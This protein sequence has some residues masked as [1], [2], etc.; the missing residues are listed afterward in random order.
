MSG[1]EIK[2]GGIGLVRGELTDGS[3]DGQVKGSCIKE[4]GSN[5]PPRWIQ[6][7]SEGETGGD[8]VVEGEGVSVWKREKCI[9][10]ARTQTHNSKDKDETA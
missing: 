4:Q 6:V 3:E 7:F 5:H 8:T 10:Q 2:L 1:S 9:L